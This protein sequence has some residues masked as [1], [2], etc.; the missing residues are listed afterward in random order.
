MRVVAGQ[1]VGTS[2]PAADATN[3]PHA[4]TYDTLHNKECKHHPQRRY[5]S[6]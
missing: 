2:T 4:S 6:E 3:K 1:Q 5:N